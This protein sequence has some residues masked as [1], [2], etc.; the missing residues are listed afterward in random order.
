MSLET[1]HGEL[2]QADLFGENTKVQNTCSQLN[3]MLTI[4]DA[5]S[6][7]VNYKEPLTYR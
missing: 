7:Y 3:D 5:N 1:F 2:Y 4:S 6:K